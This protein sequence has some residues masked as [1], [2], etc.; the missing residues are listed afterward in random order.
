MGSSE[1][2]RGL[3]TLCRGSGETA[4]P[5]ELWL[6]ICRVESIA[7]LL[8]KDILVNTVLANLAEVG[9]PEPASPG[10]ASISDWSCQDGSGVSVLRALLPSFRP[11][12]DPAILRCG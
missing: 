9:E 4:P 10:H 12:A 5:E 11:C 1:L 6:K 7:A 3:Q 8:K 2:K